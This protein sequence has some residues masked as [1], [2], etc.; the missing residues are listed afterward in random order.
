LITEKLASQN[1]LR[2]KNLSVQKALAAER[3]WREKLPVE[4]LWCRREIRCRREKV[5]L[6]L[7]IVASDTRR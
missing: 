7:G 3:F 5:G 6:C 4:S 2:Y 1:A